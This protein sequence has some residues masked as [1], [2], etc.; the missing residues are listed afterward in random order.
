MFTV[1]L[2][3]DGFILS[4]SHTDHDNVSLD[5]NKI[6]LKYLNAYKLID[7]VISLDEEKKAEMEAE[8]QEEAKQT[9]IADLK[10]S[11][12]E[13]DYIMSRMLEEIMALNNPLT[14]IAD[15]IK[16]FASYATKYKDVLAN[17]KIWR[18][19]IEELE[20]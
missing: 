18:A 13:T 20:K 1:N 9:E 14:F 19:R 2:D 10:E 7:G 6:D 8:E 11:L 16:I 12:N 4:I 17:R 15:M 3:K 5:L